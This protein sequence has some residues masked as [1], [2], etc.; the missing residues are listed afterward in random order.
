MKKPNIADYEF[1]ESGHKRYKIDLVLW[2]AH[3][4]EQ[5]EQAE[6]AAQAERARRTDDF[7]MVAGGPHVPRTRHDIY[8]SAY[9][10]AKRLA[11]KQPGTAFY[12]VRPITKVISEPPKAV[13]T[14]LS[15]DTT[16]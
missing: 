10:K 12:V 16:E 11:E 14:P 6:R 5:V 4:A 9:N 15:L 7:W 1:T 8:E 13:S 3:Q 2:E